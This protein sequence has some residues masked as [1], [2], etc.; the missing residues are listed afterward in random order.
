MAKK[1]LCID[2]S[3]NL[4]QVLKKRFEFEL[5]DVSVLTADNG[6]D[7]LKKARQES[8]DLIFLDINMP[9][10]NGDEVLADLQNPKNLLEGE[11]DTKDI[12]VI[13]L[14][15]H[16][17]EERSRYLAAGAREYISSPFDTSSLVETVR[18]LLLQ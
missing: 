1:I 11:F 12:P 14:T 5:K 9:K 16:G 15:S 18:G 2:D 8:P 10:M 17:P 3:L 13:I 4:L 7:G 6:E